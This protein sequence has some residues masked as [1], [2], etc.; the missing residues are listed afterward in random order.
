MVTPSKLSFSMDLTQVQLSDIIRADSYT[1]LRYPI[2]ATACCASTS[3]GSTVYLSRGSYTSRVALQTACLEMSAPELNSVYNES[4]ENCMNATGGRTSIA[5]VTSIVAILVGVRVF[6]YP[7]R[8][9]DI[10][11]SWHPVFPSPFAYSPT[12]PNHIIVTYTQRP[13]GGIVDPVLLHNE[14]PLYSYSPA[15]DACIT[16]FCAAFVKMRA[17]MAKPSNQAAYPVTSSSLVEEVSSQLPTS[18]PLQDLVCA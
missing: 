14:D 17:I 9:I 3:A 4:V 1:L 5:D 18:S 10:S 15:A 2:A 6:R 12:G 16:A 11:S 7:D 13:A 8:E